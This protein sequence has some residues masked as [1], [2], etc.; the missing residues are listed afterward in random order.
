[1]M[2]TAEK[3]RAHQKMLLYGLE[4]LADLGGFIR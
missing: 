3:D 2:R 4:N 1:M